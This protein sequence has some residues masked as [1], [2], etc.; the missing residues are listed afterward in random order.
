MEY[1]VL[2]SSCFKPSKL[3]PP[4]SQQSTCTLRLCLFHKGNFEAKKSAS[5][6]KNEVQF[7]EK[8][9]KNAPPTFHRMK[10]GFTTKV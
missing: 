6:W 5:S 3:E 2:V 9:K 4:W 8:Q 7:Y 10:E 1:F